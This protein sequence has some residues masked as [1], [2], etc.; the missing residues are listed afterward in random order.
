MIGDTDHQHLSVTNVGWARQ[1]INEP[2]E[3][4]AHQKVCQVDSTVVNRSAGPLLPL[5]FV[6][7]ID[8]S[9][10]PFRSSFPYCHTW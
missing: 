3:E 8:R 1:K 6:D 7:V 4:V 2:S 5:L 9:E 10:R